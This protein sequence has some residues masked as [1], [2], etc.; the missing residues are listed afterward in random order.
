[1]EPTFYISSEFELKVYL[2]TLVQLKMAS[3]YIT[4]GILYIVSDILS[5]ITVALCM[6]QKVPQIRELYTYKSAKGEYYFRTKTRT[7]TQTQKSVPCNCNN[8]NNFIG[9]IFSTTQQGLVQLH[10]CWNCSAI[11]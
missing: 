3:N 4:K 5:L 1:M 8:C 9:F 6:V 11:L 7:Q 2:F 10:C